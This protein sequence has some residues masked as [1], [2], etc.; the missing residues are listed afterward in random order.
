[1]RL[2]FGMSQPADGGV[3]DWKPSTTD[4]LADDIPH[5]DDREAEGL[6]DRQDFFFPATGHSG[7]AHDPHGRRGIEQ[8]S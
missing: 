6:R 4:L 3:G 1:M 5:A 7:N 2:T 8:S